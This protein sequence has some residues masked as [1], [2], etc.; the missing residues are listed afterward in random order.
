MS[1]TSKRFKINKQNEIGL[2]VKSGSEII[3]SALRRSNRWPT[4]AS[5]PFNNKALEEEGEKNGA[6]GRG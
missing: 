6:A 5:V 1:N 4:P 2:R 3:T